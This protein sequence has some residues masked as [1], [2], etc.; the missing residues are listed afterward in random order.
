MIISIVKCKVINHSSFFM[1]TLNQ[2]K[3]DDTFKI[4]YVVIILNSS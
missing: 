1:N 2:V 3:Q 4:I